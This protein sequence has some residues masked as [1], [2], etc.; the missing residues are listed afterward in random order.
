MDDKINATKNANYFLHAN[1]YSKP[2][3]IKKSWQL[4][5]KNQNMQ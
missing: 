3:L 2:R 4:L 1:F 5:K